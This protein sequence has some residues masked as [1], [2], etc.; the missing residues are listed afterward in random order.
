ME[1]IWKVLGFGYGVSNL[2]RIKSL[3]GAPRILRPRKNRA[4]YMRINLCMPQRA[5][6]TIHRLV[7]ETFLPNPDNLPEVNHLDGNRLN[8]KVDNLE[9]CTTSENQLHSF[10]IGL[11]TP[12]RGENHPNAKL[13]SKDIDDIRT[14]LQS[15]KQLSREYDVT[16]EHVRA[17][18]R[19]NRWEPK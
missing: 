2:G 15:P 12:K 7:A 4:G 8:N 9:W 11:H 18:R 3:K 13:S 6:Y 10:K 17:I 5:T 16:P 19:G 1:E 14:S